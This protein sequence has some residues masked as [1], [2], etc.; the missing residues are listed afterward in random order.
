MSGSI[1]DPGLFYPVSSLPLSP[2][3]SLSLSLSM[4]QLFKKEKETEKRERERDNR[5]RE[6]EERKRKTREKEERMI[7]SFFDPQNGFL[8]SDLQFKVLDVI[9][10]IIFHHVSLSVSF[11]DHVRLGTI[12]FLEHLTLSLSLT[13]SSLSL[14]SLTLSLSL[15][16]SL[17]FS[18]REESCSRRVR[19][20]R[21]ILD[22]G[23]E[24]SGEERHR[25]SEL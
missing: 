11:P 7:Q 10:C 8:L 25:G 4:K 14:S 18:C 16:L 15:S 20:D 5:G 13:L 22:Q 21:E 17:T 6:K 2:S 3:L 12:C 23:S 1:S 9:A 19:R 24:K